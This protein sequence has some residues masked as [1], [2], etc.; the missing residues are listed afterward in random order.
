VRV[1]S[2]EPTVTASVVSTG[3]ADRLRPCIASLE[4]QGLGER[5]RV[6]VVC[7]RRGDGSADL[8]RAAFPRALVVE[9]PTPRGFS[10]NHNAGLAAAPSD[11]GMVLNPDVVLRPGCL[12]ALLDVMARRARCGVVAPLLI[13]PDGRPQPSARRFP[14]PL[15]TLLRRTPLRAMFAPARFDAGHYLP[16]ATEP[17]AVDWVLGACLLVRRTAWAEL[18]GFDQAAFPRLYVEDIDLGWRMWQ[19]GWEVWQTPE[20]VAVHEHQAATDG[21]FF[22]RRTLWHLQGMVNFVRKH[23]SVL[24]GLSP[25]AAAGRPRTGAPGTGAD[26]GSAQRG[27]AHVGVQHHTEPMAPGQASSR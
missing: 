25:G 18:G 24:A 13:Y 16:E 14:R 5:L 7:N 27:S 21:R 17:R 6:V 20:A 1:T 23:P 12:R 4:A 3:E 2:G 26:G 15:G 8:V 10:E 19:G 22:Q 9:Q 11:F